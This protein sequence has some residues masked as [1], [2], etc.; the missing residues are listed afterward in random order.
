MFGAVCP[1]LHKYPVATELLSDNDCPSQIVFI[2]PVVFIVGVA[3]IGL[4]VIFVVVEVGEEQL[5]PSVTT[6]VIDDVVETII[7]EVVSPVDHKYENPTGA[8]NVIFPPLQKAVGPD[9]VIEGEEGSGFE[10]TD[11]SEEGTLQPFALEI[12]TETV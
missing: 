1:L 12:T 6:N 8:V 4:T 10:T 7:V 5:F 3:G 2:P 11:T 9:G